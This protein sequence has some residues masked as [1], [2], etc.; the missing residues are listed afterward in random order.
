MTKTPHSRRSALRSRPLPRGNLKSDTSSS[1]V[2]LPPSRS[3]PAD[4]STSRPATQETPKAEI[5]QTGQ[6]NPAIPLLIIQGAPGELWG[7]TIW[8]GLVKAVELK[9]EVFN[10]AAGVQGVRDVW[11][12]MDGVP[13]KLLCYMEVFL[14]QHQPWLRP[15]GMPAGNEGTVLL[16]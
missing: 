5:P 3:A 12:P 7:L 16:R 14:D 11:S 10:D 13:A 15:R 1:P 6:L 8:K 9:K 4:A 2:N